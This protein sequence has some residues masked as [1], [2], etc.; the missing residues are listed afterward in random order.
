M[1]IRKRKDATLP[2]ERRQE[3]QDLLEANRRRLQAEIDRLTDQ[4]KQTPDLESGG[5][6]GDRAEHGLDQDISART[7]EQLA[8]MLQATEQALARNTEEEYGFCQSCGKEIPL[9]RLRALPFALYCREC[10]ER[11]ES[12]SP[13][14]PPRM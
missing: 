2:Q 6:V 10:Q 13:G 11:I 4:M 9:E 1:A 8:Q 3:L 12:P 7:M 14:N 5:D